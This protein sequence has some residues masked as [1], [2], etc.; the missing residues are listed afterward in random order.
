MNYQLS[1]MNDAFFKYCLGKENSESRILREFLLSHVVK[2]DYSH[3]KVMNPELIPEMIY[4]KNMILDILLK[5]DN[6]TIGIDMQATPLSKHLYKRFQQYLSRL[7]SEQVVIGDRYEDIQPTVMILFAKDYNK[8]TPSLII[9][10]NMMDMEY[11]IPLPNSIQKFIIIQ[12][13]YIETIAREKEKLSEFEAWIYLIYKNTLDG[14]EYEEKKGVITIMK[15]KK[16]KY[17]KEEPSLYNAAMDR[18]Y[19]TINWDKA[20]EEAVEEAVEQS[21]EKAIK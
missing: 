18:W 13:P 2:E 19:F 4:Q 9:E 20:L 1:Y 11:L 10:K 15:E 3:L 16:E 7:C 17:V 5:N 21:K 12:L 6:M 14:I 8:E